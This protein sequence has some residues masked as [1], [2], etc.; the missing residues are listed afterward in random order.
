M[1]DIQE[2]ERQKDEIEMRK[3]QMSATIALTEQA[4]KIQAL[5]EEVEL[6]EREAVREELGSDFESEDEK[7]PDVTQVNKCVV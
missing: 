5:E 3:K 7:R 2:L 6:R 4:H 1:R